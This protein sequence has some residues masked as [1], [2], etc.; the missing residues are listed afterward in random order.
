[1]VGFPSSTPGAGAGEVIGETPDFLL[2][3]RPQ[4]KDP[5][6]SMNI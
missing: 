4:Q 2:K 5:Q 6:N 3:D 1:M